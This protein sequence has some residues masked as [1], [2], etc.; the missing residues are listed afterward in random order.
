VRLGARQYVVLGAGLDTFG[1][2]NPHSGLR[3]FEVDHPATQAWKRKRLETAGI[4]IPATVTFAPVDFEH[5]TLSDGLARA[6]LHQ[7]ATFFSWLG[8]VPYLTRD[9]VL[10]TFRLIASFP[11]PSGAV[12]DYA[13][14][15][16]SLNWKGKLALDAISARVAKA[17]EP[18]QTF[19]DPAEMMGILQLLG[20]GNIEDLHSDDINALYFLN[21]A[22]GLR[23]AGD[24]GRL[25]CA[26]VGT[27]ANS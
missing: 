24:I 23:V 9:A 18:F 2:R 15:R 27:A 17:G 16:S 11:S 4:P 3:V 12:F 5:Q 8:V 26:W 21:R 20:F 6:G 10:A 14:P 22:D 25:L 19:F 1:Y 13:V 7:E